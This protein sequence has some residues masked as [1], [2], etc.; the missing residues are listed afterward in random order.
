MAYDN[1]PGDFHAAITPSD[2]VNIP[3]GWTRSIYVGVTGDVALVDQNDAVVVWKAVPVGILPMRAKRINST[4]TT[5]TN[6]V[7]IW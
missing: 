2:T 3:T 7:A 6:M 5:A 4:A 1:G